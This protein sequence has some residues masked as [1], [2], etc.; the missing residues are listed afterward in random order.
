MK[1]KVQN[2][3][4]DTIFVLIVFSIFAFSVLMV[5]MLGAGIYKN[6]TEISRDGQNER[7]VLSY[8]RTKAK[9]YDG[10]DRV[11]LDDFNG[12]TALRIDEE[13]GETSYRTFIYHYDGWLCELFSETSLDFDPVDGIQISRIDDLS[14]EDLENGL[15]K[16][17]AGKMNMLLS[18]RGSTDE[19]IGGRS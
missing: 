5:L 4:I 8:V 19:P 9:N 7:T 14:F 2:R 13:Y 3:K 15:I 6:M 18:P 12:I 1:K 11:Y 16:V 10:A 17:T